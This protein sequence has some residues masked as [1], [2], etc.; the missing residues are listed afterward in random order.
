MVSQVSGKL[1]LS[2]YET[3]ILRAL[4]PGG[5]VTGAPKEQSMKIIDEIENYQRGIYT[6]SLGFITNNGYMDFNIAIR[7][8]MVKGDVG[9]YPVGGGI[10][11]E[12]D[13]TSEWFEAH[14]KSAIL[15]PFINKQKFDI[16]EFETSYITS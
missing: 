5:S 7:T 14:Q 10:V 6:G 15:Y 1:K 13:A 3:D 4:F 2:I 9:I 11:W 16:T 12:S 8:L